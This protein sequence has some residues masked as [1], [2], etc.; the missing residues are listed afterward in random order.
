MET[1][2]MN[3]FIATIVAMV[4]KNLFA[5]LVASGV[6][7]AVS[8]VVFTTVIGLSGELPATIWVVLFVSI[9]SLVLAGIPVGL[10]ILLFKTEKAKSTS[11]HYSGNFEREITNIIFLFVLASAFSWILIVL[12][13][14]W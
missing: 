11:E 8:M 14:F 9:F 7:L 2:N 6:L 4:Y 12:I 13:W 10:S 3:H 5:A 1:K